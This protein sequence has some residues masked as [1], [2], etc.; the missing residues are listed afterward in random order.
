M[1]RGVN[2]VGAGP[3][4]AP[5]THTQAH[6]TQGLTDTARRVIASMSKR[7]VQ[8]KMILSGV[9]SLI[10]IAISV[11]IYVTTKKK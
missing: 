11:T 10:I 4:C 1:P 7:E 9:A 5:P 8:Q 6:E 2:A 3:H